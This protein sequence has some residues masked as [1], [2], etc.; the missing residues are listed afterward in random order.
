MR[1]PNILIFMTDHQRGDTVWPTHP[2]LTPAV[3]RL[4]Q[5]GITF[6]QAF[7]PSPHCCPSRA[8]FFS[9][10]YPSR[11]GIWNNVTDRQALS[12]S[13]KDGV[14]LWSEDLKQAGYDLYFSGKWHVSATRFPEDYGFED[15]GVTCGKS[16]FHGRDWSYYQDLAK[17]PLPA[18]RAE[19]EI[20]R[21]GYPAYQL[22]G[23]HPEKDEWHDERVLAQA[24]DV[25]KTLKGH[26]KPWGHFIGLLGP[27][28]P[29]LVPDKYLAL[30][31]LASVPLPP[32]YSDTMEDKPALYRRMRRTRFGQLSERETRDAIR[33]FWAYCSYLDFQF[34]QV[35]AALEATGQAE[36]TLVLYVSDHGDYCGEHGLFAKGIPCFRGA[37]HVPAIIRWSAGI[38]NPGRTQEAFV[39]LADFAPTFLEAA[40]I[41]PNRPFSGQSLI[42]FLRNEEPPGWRDTVFTQCNGVELYVTQRSVITKEYKY[43]FNGF[44][45]D[46][47]YDLRN[48]PHE[49]KNLS[50]D[51]A[52]EEIKKQMCIRLWHECQKEDDTVANN[53]YITVALAPYGPAC[54][55]RQD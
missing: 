21:P 23:V 49:M 36:D 14:R 13:L 10:L 26:A 9:G 47:L 38:K 6:S 44:D 22:Y 55:F 31:D 28:D 24:L 37:Y 8:T 35:L 18:K 4:A 42:P 16:T 40:G 53:P 29:Y 7:C 43:V 12:V 51:P 27:H 54:A 48:D 1:N 5:E 20:L 25:L 50:F 2:A 19:G 30:Y 34:S 52:Y 46:E 3:E 41:K 32:N 45:E 39:S 17:A 11:H 33:H 15:R